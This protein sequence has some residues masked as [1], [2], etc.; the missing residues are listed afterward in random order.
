MMKMLINHKYQKLLENYQK[1]TIG[2][3]FFLFF[4]FKY[5][6][7]HHCKILWWKNFFVKFYS[8]LKLYILFKFEAFN[9]IILHRMMFSLTEKINRSIIIFDIKWKKKKKKK[10][11]KMEIGETFLLHMKLYLST[12]IIPNKLTNFFFFVFINSIWEIKCG[13]IVM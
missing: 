9:P 2:S 4:S 5:K 3:I 7:Y 11:K 13:I 12:Y 6:K 1:I 8:Y 10:L